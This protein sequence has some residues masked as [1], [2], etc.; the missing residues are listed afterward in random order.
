M[1]WGLKLP[2]A[3]LIR[4]NSVKSLRW[5]HWGWRENLS[6]S[7]E[8]Q[9]GSDIWKSPTWPLS[10]L[11]PKMHKASKIKQMPK[12][13]L[14]ESQQSTESSRNLIFLLSSH[15]CYWETRSQWLRGKLQGL[16]GGGKTHSQPFERRCPEYLVSCCLTF[17]EWERMGLPS[18]WIFKIY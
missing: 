3:T 6:S 4:I 13:S 1:H 15:T 18:S 2:C 10:N 11:Q 7:P 9:A 14:N 5:E 8:Q 16:V 17:L 12:S